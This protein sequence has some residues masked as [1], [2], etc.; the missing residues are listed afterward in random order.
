MIEAVLKRFEK[1][2]KTGSEF[3]ALCPAHKDK[4]PSLSIREENGRVLLHCHAGCTFDAVREAAGLDKGDLNGDLSAANA[5]II[6]TYDYQDETGKT[7][8]QVVRF[9]PKSFKQRRPD[10]HGGWIW[11]V[12]GVRKV[13]YRLPELV[14]AEQVFI[15]EGERDVET[16]RGLGLVATCN[17]GGAEKWISEYGEHLRGKNVVVIADNDEPGQK[18]ALSVARSLHLI[19]ASLKVVKALPMPEGQSVKDVT[20]WVSHAFTGKLLVALAADTPAWNPEGNDSFHIGGEFE[21]KETGPPKLRFRTALQ[22]LTETPEKIE[23][24]AKPYVALGAI[25]E[26]DGKVKLA[27]KTTWITHLCRAVLDGLPFMGE[28]TTK[29]PVVYLTEQPPSS[30]RLTLERAGLLGREDFHCLYFRDI[31]GIAW[32]V[33]ADEAVAYCHRVGAKLLVIDTLGQFAGIAGDSENNAGDAL[34][35]M[36]PLQEA[37]GQGIAV[38]ISRHDRKSGGLVGES[39]RG[40]SA[41]S[42]AVDIVLSIR[43]P[44]GNTKKTL[45][46]IHAVGRFDET[47]EELVIDLTPTGYVSLGSAANVAEGAAEQV[48]LAGAPRTPEEA[49]TL[50]ELIKDSEVSRSTANRVAKSMCARGALLFI[51]KGKRGDAFRYFLPES[52]SFQTPNTGVER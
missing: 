39:G 13:P 49:V 16:I 30:W 31:R 21:K 22:V 9:A 15:V 27:G 12:H 35:A 40:S 11:N 19:A 14:A 7:L 48:M 20:E 33:V 28:P 45:R 36:M 38:M 50:D 44:E 18:H 1:V 5:K 47:P 2:K 25:T 37:A 32:Q 6:G 42:G 24:I 23:W 43:R 46:T 51:G 3:T 52:V 29:S 34:Q 26:V 8:F 10:G 17:P 4:S 41:Y